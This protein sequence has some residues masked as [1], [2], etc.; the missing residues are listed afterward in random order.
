MK[1]YSFFSLILL[2]GTYE[3]DAN[4]EEEQFNSPIENIPVD[5]ENSKKRISF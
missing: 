2:I 4:L 5:T 1:A 3:G